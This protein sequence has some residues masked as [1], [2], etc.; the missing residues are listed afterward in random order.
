MTQLSKIYYGV[1]IALHLI[2]LFSLLNAQAFHDVNHY[3][4]N[5]KMF[6]ENQEPPHIPLV[7]FTST[8]I[9]LQN[10]WSKSPYYITLDGIWKFNWAVNLY[11]APLNFYQETFD[12]SKWDDIEVPSVWQMK[13]YGWNIYRN[14]P[15]E[16]SPYDPPHVPDDI[17]PVGSYRRSFTIPENWSGRQIFLHFNG[18]KSAAFVWINGKYVGYDQGSMTASEYNITSFVKTGENILAVK[19]IRWSDGSYLECQDMW[20][21]SGIYRSVYLFATPNVHIRD[22]FIRTNLDENY[23]DATLQTSVWLHN[24]GEVSAGKYSVQLKLYDKRESVVVSGKASKNLGAGQEVQIELKQQVKN[25]LKWSAE[26]P[27][28]YKLILKLIDPNGNVSEVLYDHIGFREIELVN[29]IVRINGVP[30]EFRGV[31]RHEHHPEHG[32]TMPLE[33]MRKDL[34][35]MKQFNV[36]TVRLSH[37]PNDPDWYVMADKY[38]VYLID[39]VNT[40]THYAES[41]VDG[42]YGMDWF[43]EQPSWQDAFFERF[44]RMLQRDKNRPSVVIW[45]TG[46]ETGTGPVMF[47]QAEYARKVDGTRLVM[48]QT[49]HPMG[50]A[51]YVDIY[52]PRYP[53][54]EKVRYYALNEKR[55]VVMGEYMHAIGNSVGNFDEFWDIIRQYPHLQGG[56]IWDWVDQGLR[57]KLILTTDL[58]QNAN[59]GAVMG[60][61]EVVTGKFGKAI[62]LSGLD[63]YIEIYNHPNLDITGTQ[64]TVEAWIYPR[65]CQKYNPIVTKGIQQ[66]TLEQQHP[67]S[68]QFYIHNGR[69]GTAA[70]GRVPNDWDYN[71]HHIAGIYDGREIKL[72][73]DGEVVAT[74]EFSGNINRCH[75]PVGIGKNV[76]RNNSKYA[77]RFSNSVIDNVRIYPRAIDDSELGFYRQ[78]PA[79]DAELVL[80]LDDFNDTGNTFFSYG[81]DP[82]CINGTIFADRSV[83]PET[84]QVKRSHAPVRVKPV[85]LTNGKV[86]IFNY[87]HFTNLNELNT[88]WRIHTADRELEG[89]ALTLDVAPLS[90]QVIT[91]P[92]SAPELNPGDE[93]WLTISFLLPEA[94]MWAPQGHEVAFDQFKLPF[95]APKGNKVATSGASLSLKQS[96][97]QLHIQGKDF[98]YKFD[99]EKGTLTSLYFQGNELL[100]DGP[101]L[102]VYRP[103]ISNEGS[104]WGHDRDLKTYWEAEEWWYYGF[105]EVE[106]GVQSIQ[107]EETSNSEIKITVQ[108]LWYNVVT[109]RG[110]TGFECTYE[111]TFLASGDILLRHVINPFGDELSYLQKAGVRIK[112]ANEL[113]NITWY[114]RGP[115]ET[116]PD[117]KTGAKMGIY[118]ETVDQQYVPYVFPQEHGNKTE[119]RWVSLSNADGVGLAVFAYPEMNVN[120]SNYDPDNVDR[121]RYG[122][123]LQKADYVTLNIDHKVTG[124][125]DTPVPPRFQYRTWPL[126]YDYILRFRPFSEKTISASDLNRQQ[127]K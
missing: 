36:N 117:R 83:Q 112:L 100:K 41:N 31:N 9:A 16:F 10:D 52:G 13:G 6:A 40:E 17:N 110:N 105:D 26:K 12:A 99:K 61:P 71:W 124:V 126:P 43:P 15:Q 8:Q 33:M 88:V 58:S 37:Y 81:S 38:G 65:D 122:F 50:D 89:G 53:S 3:I 25:P 68:L 108:T 78:D 45:S 74:E 48:H 75:F 119:V 101:K 96:G 46:N 39:E 22:F 24:Y 102:S 91:V 2:S 125:G 121:A 106:E 62:Q 49:N 19:V 123:Q 111:Y 95:N 55:P 93:A 67:D 32:R 109:R 57:Q 29:G 80:N 56:F 72:L 90:D 69:S 113:Q 116:Y 76:Q 44:E 54:P 94:T 63:D 51:P 115:F 97:N 84:W 82:F 73:I 42:K 98:I 103:I 85:D 14:I 18:I 104:D 60:N 30:I 59:H 87:H 70:K 34:E 79:P 35:L 7:P 92:Y 5:P 86:K 23:E 114:G 120:A 1:M 118:K 47:K 11:E 77:G 27:N 127:V 4:E 107:V 21:F 28:L 20:R 64:I 66:Y